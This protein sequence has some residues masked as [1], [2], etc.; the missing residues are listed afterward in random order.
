MHGQIACN[1]TD[2][3]H[4]VP[5]EFQEFHGLVHQRLENDEGYLMRRKHSKRT[6]FYLLDSKI[7]I[8]IFL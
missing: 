3:P 8:T 6:T 5:I 1:R 2:T 7:I 4:A